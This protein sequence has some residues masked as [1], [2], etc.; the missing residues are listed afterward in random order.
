MQSVSPRS[1]QNVSLLPV[2]FCPHTVLHINFSQELR[3]CSCR[4]ALKSMSPR[5]LSQLPYDRR[6]C[7]SP[8]TDRKTSDIWG[9]LPPFLG[10]PSDQSFHHPEYD[11][12]R[13]LL[14]PEELFQISRH[15]AIPPV[16]RNSCL[17]RFY[18]YI[19]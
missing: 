6:S 10:N 11:N 16:I 3:C 7:S 12:R 14:F 5:R 13:R 4:S 15:P 17:L 8:E 9:T 18:N 1:L 2:Y 19:S